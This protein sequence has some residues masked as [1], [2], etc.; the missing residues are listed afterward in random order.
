MADFESKN[1]TYRSLT[2][3]KQGDGASVWSGRTRVQTRK[4]WNHDPRFYASDAHGDFQQDI[5]PS[6]LVDW[7]MDDWISRVYGSARSQK[8]AEV[9]VVHH[10]G[11]HGQ[12]YN[13]TAS[14]RLLLER[15]I[16]SGKA[17][18]AAHMEIAGMPIAIVDAF[19]D[20]HLR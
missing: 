1:F 15:L 19:R 3:S 10:T 8:L 9:E 14:N 18:I 11:T 5:L 7:W 13:V 16:L 20:S 6:E 4:Y 12:R 17:Q 2:L